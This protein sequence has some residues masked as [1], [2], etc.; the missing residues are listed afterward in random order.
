M[1]IIITTFVTIGL[2]IGS[3]LNYAIADCPGSKYKIHYGSCYTIPP[4]GKC[5]EYLADVVKTKTEKKDTIHVTHGTN[6]GMTCGGRSTC[7]KNS[8][9]C[10]KCKNR[11]YCPP[12]HD[13]NVTADYC[14]GKTDSGRTEDGCVSKRVAFPGSPL[15]QCHDVI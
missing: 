10:K 5:S 11:S 9:G 3:S 15:Y 12:K 8:F 1:K 14:V 7:K 13:I 2:F 4:G 6:C